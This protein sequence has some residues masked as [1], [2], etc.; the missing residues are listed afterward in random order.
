V[1][2]GLSLTAT[3]LGSGTSYV[4]PVKRKNGKI[5]SFVKTASY[6]TGLILR[7]PLLSN[8][9]EDSVLWFRRI[10]RQ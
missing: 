10:S 8:P 3:E 6:K 7:T 1:T 2:D 5:L 4:D 9:F